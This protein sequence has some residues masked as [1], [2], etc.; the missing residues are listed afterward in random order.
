MHNIVWP[1]GHELSNQSK[2]QS[3]PSNKRLDLDCFDHSKSHVNRA[4]KTIRL[5]V[6][7]QESRKLKRVVFTFIF[8]MFVSLF[9]AHERVQ[10]RNGGGAEREWKRI[11]S[12]LHASHGAR[13]GAWYLPTVRSWPESTSRVRCL[14][15]WTA[16]GFPH[17]TVRKKMNKLYKGLFLNLSEH[18]VSRTNN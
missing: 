18:W 3:N 11:S 12:R 16:Q 17:F 4:L 13:Q 8:L 14:T 2:K 5:P 6:S 10:E 15:Q 7:N 1:I 9:W